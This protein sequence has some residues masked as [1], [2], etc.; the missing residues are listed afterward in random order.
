MPD[1]GAWLNTALE[2][3]GRSCPS[4]GEVGCSVRRS[5]VRA[6][7]KLLPQLIKCTS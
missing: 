4:E 3:A 2:E 7:G 6:G 1:S 5:A